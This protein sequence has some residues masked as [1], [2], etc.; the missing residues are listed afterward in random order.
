MLELGVN[1]DHVATVREARGVSYPSPLEAALICEKAGGWGITAHLREDRRHMQDADMVELK[2]SV[3]RLN[4]EMA[5]TEEMI[6]IASGLKPYSSCLVPEKR[7][8]LTTEGGLNVIGDIEWLKEAVGSLQSSGIIVSIFIDPDMKQLD[9]AKE[10]NAEYV[11]LHTGSYANSTGDNAQKELK[12][13]IAAAEY[14]DSIGLKVNAGH[15]IDYK[16][17]DGILRIPHLCELNIGHSIVSRA[18][19]V[20]MYNAVAEMIDLMKGY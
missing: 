11:E 16:N 7:E 2:G 18:V 8:E 6:E 13:L 12:R 17:I 10:L 15:G 1:V 14:A 19:I 3:K 5:A 9:A 4:M 20:G